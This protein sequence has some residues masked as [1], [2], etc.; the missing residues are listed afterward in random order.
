[1]Q[2]GTFPG[3]HL[4]TRAGSRRRHDYHQNERYDSSSTQIQRSQMTLVIV[5]AFAGRWKSPS[6]RK[7]PR[8]RF[9]AASIDRP[10]STEPLSVKRADVATLTRPAKKIFVRRILDELMTN[11]S[12]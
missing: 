11:R 2:P 9:F 4:R 10:G 12:Q 3:R 6:E 5:H 7:I 1:M 8:K